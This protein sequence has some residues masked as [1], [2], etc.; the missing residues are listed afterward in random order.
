MNVQEIQYRVKNCQKCHLCHTLPY[1]D[2]E[3][4]RCTPVAGRGDFKAKLMLVGKCPGSDE[5]AYGMPFVGDSGKLLDKMLEEADIKRENCYTSNVV[6][7]WSRTPDLKSN[8]PLK[9]DEIATCKHFLWWE[10]QE[11]EPEVIVTLGKVPTYTLLHTQLN[12]TFSILKII[13]QEYTVHYCN[14]SI[15]PVPHPSFLL[16]R[17]KGMIKDVV[18]IFKNIRG[19]LNE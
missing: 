19:R 8:R 13:G 7:C 17:N 4:K 12:K 9:N 3:E 14:S 1:D 18:E 15:I 2:I 6:R 5:V 10:I 11:I 16:Q